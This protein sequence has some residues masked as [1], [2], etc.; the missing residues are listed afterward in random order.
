MHRCII[1][2]NQ[3]EH[4]YIIK[5]QQIAQHYVIETSKI[6]VLF[7]GIFRHITGSNI[8]NLYQ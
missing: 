1:I 8:I 6:L 5:L 7:H 4:T 3:T 2:V